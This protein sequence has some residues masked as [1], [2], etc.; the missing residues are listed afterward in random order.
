MR[1]KRTQ[2][3]SRLDTTSP[4][5]TELTLSLSKRRPTSPP[6]VM[7]A[8]AGIQSTTPTPFQNKLLTGNHTSNLELYTPETISGPAG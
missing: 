4:E 8:Q 5:F 2:I 1:S 6:T 3:K 7:P